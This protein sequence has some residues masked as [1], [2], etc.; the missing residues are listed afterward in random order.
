MRWLCA[1]PS[2][3]G[4]HGGRGFAAADEQGGHSCCSAKSK[5]SSGPSTVSTVASASACMHCA[6][7]TVT[8]ASANARSVHR[9]AGRWCATSCALRARVDASGRPTWR[10][11]C[12]PARCA[13]RPWRFAVDLH[14]PR[15]S[16]GAPTDASQ[17]AADFEQK[18]RQAQCAQRGSHHG[19]LRSPW[20]C[21]RGRARCHPV[22]AESRHAASNAS[23]CQPTRARASAS[24]CVA[25]RPP[26][27]CASGPK[28][29]QAINGPTVGSIAP[30]LASA[31]RRAQAMTSANSCASTWREPAGARL[32]RPD[33]RIRFP[34]AHLRDHPRQRRIDGFLHLR[35]RKHARVVEAQ[36]PGRAHGLPAQLLQG[37]GIGAARNGGVGVAAGA[38][39][40]ERK[41][42][43]C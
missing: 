13:A 15:L 39:G 20:Q 5:P 25:G 18:V 1:R 42:Q 43:G 10:R 38:P 30:P 7:S 19:R 16:V 33:V 40:A 21:R 37:R 41:S 28:P 34:V 2:A 8:L 11:P 35:Q 29:Q 4:S 36:R 31:H 17:L 14:L 27:S 9:C 26:S 24:T 32:K 12:R 23:R 22:A 6:C 3:R